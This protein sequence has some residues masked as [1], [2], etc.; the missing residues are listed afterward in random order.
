MP[1]SCELDCYIVLYFI[2]YVHKIQPLT[3]INDQIRIQRKNM[4]R[5]TNI[6]KISYLQKDLFRPNKLIN[7]QL[8]L[9]SIDS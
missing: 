1:V 9:A 5:S 3:T 7:I 8:V 6:N 2:Y 4:S